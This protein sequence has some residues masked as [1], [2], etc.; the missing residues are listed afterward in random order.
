LV[1][2]ELLIL[3]LLSGFLLS[4]GSI[5]KPSSR[6]LL[7]THSSVG[8]LTSI[9]KGGVSSGHVE[10]RSLLLSVLGLG[11]AVGSL[12]GVEV[13]L[14]ELNVLHFHG[15]ASSLGLV[16][17][18]D[19]RRS[20]SG[21]DSVGADFTLV[22][23]TNV[24]VLSHID[25]VGE[26][27][28]GALSTL[29]LWLR[30]EG[31]GEVSIGIRSGATPCGIVHLSAVLIL[32]ASGLDLTG[33]IELLGIVS[34]EAEVPSALDALSAFEVGIVLSSSK[35]ATDSEHSSAEARAAAHGRGV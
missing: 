20:T 7:L 23:F 4:L 10:L 35:F 32:A 17:E 22:Q 27:D 30:T 21:L 34:N 28:L 18:H 9:T 31:Q 26:V 16:L 14:I 6:S 12:S 3:A 5:G 29:V 19:G 15:V 13:P 11:A 25:V 33:S 8:R 1:V 24:E 2:V